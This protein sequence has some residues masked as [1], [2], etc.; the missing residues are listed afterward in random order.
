MY[1][2]IVSSVIHFG[3][4]YL[5][6]VYFKMDMLG[7]S[8]A[9]TIHFFLRFLVTVLCIRFSSQFKDALV[10]LNDPDNFKNLRS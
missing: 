3:V 9:S 1:S 2:N 4:A 10:P 8:I 5:L 6:A 7:I